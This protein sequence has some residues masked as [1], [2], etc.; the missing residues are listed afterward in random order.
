MAWVTRKWHHLDDHV[1]DI[2]RSGQARDGAEISMRAP[3]GGCGNGLIETGAKTWSN[4]EMGQLQ[5]VIIISL[6]IF[7]NLAIFF[8]Q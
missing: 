4:K 3:S 8:Q 7:D 6:Y 5:C 1:G 2:G